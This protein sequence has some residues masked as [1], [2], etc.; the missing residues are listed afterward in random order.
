MKQTEKNDQAKTRERAGINDFFVAIQ[1]SRVNELNYHS[2]IA[3]ESGA[4]VSFL[5]ESCR[6][7]LTDS[8]KI[9]DAFCDSSFSSE[10]EK[11]SSSTPWR[12]GSSSIPS[13][14]SAIWARSQL[15]RS[16]SVLGS[17]DAGSLGSWW[18]GRWNHRWARVLSH[19]ARLWDWEEERDWTQAEAWWPCHSNG[20]S[21]LGRT[22]GNHRIWS[23]PIR[24]RLSLSV[25]IQEIPLKKILASSA[26]LF[27]LIGSLNLAANASD[28]NARQQA[29]KAICPI[30]AGANGY[31]GDYQI[32][33]AVAVL[34]NR[35]YSINNHKAV[36]LN[37]CKQFL[38][39]SVQVPSKYCNSS[40]KVDAHFCI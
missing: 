17:E 40:S 21:V 3:T 30:A 1:Y 19:Q 6:T 36:A 34:A 35:S 37:T 13:P 23:L 39:Q 25:E 26:A 24:H 9:D 2:N 20:T 14:C 16:L 33:A 5:Y 12:S 7:C 29:L 18:I 11:E 15:R 31:W 27:T 10:K 4:Y 8:I 38:W 22:K 28:E 32:N